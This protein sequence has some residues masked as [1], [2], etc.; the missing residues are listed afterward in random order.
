MQFFYVVLDTHHVN[1]KHPINALKAI[2]GNNCHRRDVTI[3]TYVA[4]N[5]INV[6]LLERVEHII[7][8]EFREPFFGQSSVYTY[9]RTYKDSHLSPQSISPLFT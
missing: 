3:L 5:L 9:Y 6:F 2:V 7:T 4:N 8:Q 1:A